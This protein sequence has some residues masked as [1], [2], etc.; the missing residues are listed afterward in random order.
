MKNRQAGIQIKN[1]IK[2][3]SVSLMDR[4]NLHHHSLRQYCHALTGSPWEG[5][6]LVQDT[7]LKVWSALHRGLKE[8]QVTL[9]YLYRVA[10]NAWIDQHRKKSPAIIQQPLEEMQQP[11]SDPMEVW[12][13]M[14]TL[15]QQLAPGQRTAFL[16]VEV[17]KY[18]PAEAAAMMKSSEGAIKAALH[19]A[20]TKLRS[21]A[22]RNAQPD[23]EI[24]RAAGATGSILYPSLLKEQDETGAGN[25]DNSSSSSVDEEYLKTYAYVEAFRQQNTAALVLLMNDGTKASDAVSLL[26]AQARKKT[27][28]R[29]VRHI[30]D[31][32]VHGMYLS[33]R[34]A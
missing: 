24:E 12:V 22:S 16:L 17:L 28:V 10:R 32:T 14:E 8:E 21:K 9:P 27:S 19:R 20:R 23:K 30:S 4:I 33:A 25:T 7:W 31:Q 15:V 18:T 29:Q 3:S 6:D 2:G 11:A 26:Y 5:D 1:S 34:A 13:A